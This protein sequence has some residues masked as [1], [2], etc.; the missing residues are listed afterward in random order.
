MAGSKSIG[1]TALPPIVHRFSLA[2]DADEVLDRLGVPA[3]RGA[4]RST[5]RGR[6]P[7]SSVS[8]IWLL[9]TPRV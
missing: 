7:A 1:S 9:T 2:P 6:W 3:D 4:P 8:D 5:S